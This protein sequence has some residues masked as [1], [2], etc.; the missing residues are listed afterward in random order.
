[1]PNASKEG[2]ESFII[3]SRFLAYLSLFKVVS[4]PP[5]SMAKFPPPIFSLSDKTSTNNAGEV[6]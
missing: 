1:M 4:S 5:S 3:F 2:E 6:Q